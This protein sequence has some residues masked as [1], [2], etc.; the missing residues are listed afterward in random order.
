MSWPAFGEAVYWFFAVLIFVYM[1][2]VI[3]FYTGL[4]GLSAFQLKKESRWNRT[5]EHDEDMNAHYTKPVTVLV[6]AYNEEKGVVDTVRSLLSLRYPQVEILVINDGSSDG[7]LE[8]MIEHFSMK[9]VNRTVRRQLDTAP[10]HGIYQSNILPHL[11]LV[12]K[13]NGG[14]ADA[15]NAGIN[16]SRYPYFCSID[17]DSILESDALLKVM[18]PV[19]KSGDNIVASGGSV[20][21]ANGC[22]IQQG[23]VLSTSVSKRPIVIMQIIEYVRAFLISRVGLSR[24]NLLMIISGAFSVFQKKAV[25]EAGGYHTDTVGEDMELVVRL[26]RIN[27]EEKKNQQISYVTEPVCW[28]EAPET[29]KGLQRQRSRWHRG[30]LESLWAHKRMTMNPKYGKVGTVAFPYFWIVEMFG[31]VIEFTGY[32]F[33]IVSFFMGEVYWQFGL[34]LLL[35]MVL[36]GSL[37]S[38]GAVLLEVW[39]LNKYPRPRDMVALFFYS[40][41]ETFWYRPLTVLFRLF[42]IGQWIF[43]YRR[44]DPQERKGLSRPKVAD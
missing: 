27:K 2:I 38:L 20:R 43:K 37:L 15:L 8:T 32:L 26:H 18:K 22:D 14:K 10:V 31:P 36:Y 44:W 23:A 17:G 13:E 42:G 29:M 6:P 11:Y 39:S 3:F 21:I 19:I 4:L 40:L 12:D 16:I 24:F 41:T 30:M 25:I 7:T 5:M 1:L 34:A 33:L 35:M 9:P 28:T